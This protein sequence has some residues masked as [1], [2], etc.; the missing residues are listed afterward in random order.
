ML[1]IKDTPGNRR[2]AAPALR[3]ETDFVTMAMAV[4]TVLNLVYRLSSSLDQHLTLSAL[5]FPTSKP[6]L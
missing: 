1:S 6:L 4:V 5:S 3:V 2:D